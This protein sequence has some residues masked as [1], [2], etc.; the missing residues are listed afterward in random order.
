MKALRGRFLLLL[1]VAVALLRLGIAETS[2]VYAGPGGGQARAVVIPPGGIA[3]T[4]EILQQAGVIAHPFVFRMSAWWTHK[5]GPIRAGE[6]LL[7]AHASIRDILATLRFAPPVQHRVT[8]PEGLTG[9]QIANIVNAVPAATGTVAAP[10]NGS[11]LPQTYDYTY[12]TPRPVILHRAQAA[13][14]AA[15]DA[16]WRQRDKRVI[17][18][19]AWQALVL[20][21][22]VQE[23]TPVAA[24]LP[25]IAAVYENRLAM[26][27]RLQADPTVIFAASAGKNAGGLPVTRADLANPSPFNTYVHAGLPPGPICAPGIAAIDAVL[28][29]TA[30]NAL[31]FVATGTGGHVFTN[32]FVTQLENIQKYRAARRN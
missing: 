19:S 2:E 14:T 8:I 13:M 9:Q 3:K 11:V 18:T 27:M 15:L 12:H 5:D 23:E 32:D 28:H 10:P 22:I 20:A 21:S 24:E 30:T 4:A 26:G 16:A 7:P 1:C 6:F 31:Y 29:P 17:L 25:Q